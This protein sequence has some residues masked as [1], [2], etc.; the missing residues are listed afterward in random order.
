MLYELLQAD[1]QA[2]QLRVLLA[3]CAMCQWANQVKVQRKELL[4]LAKVSEGGCCTALKVLE[5]RGYIVRDPDNPNYFEL[6]PYICWRGSNDEWGRARAAYFEKR[7][8]SESGA[9]K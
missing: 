8:A 3:L 7:I 4:A 5:A 9:T 2:N 1:M 6:D